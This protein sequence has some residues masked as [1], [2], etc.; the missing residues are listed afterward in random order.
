MFGVCPRVF[1]ELGFAFTRT[2]YFHFYFIFHKRLAY[3]CVCGA[4]A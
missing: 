4:P 3:A 2:Y 1:L